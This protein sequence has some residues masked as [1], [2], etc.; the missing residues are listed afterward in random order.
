MNVAAPPQCR[1]AQRAVRVEG[2]VDEDGD[3]AGHGATPP[4]SRGEPVA[5]LS[6]SSAFGAAQGNAEHAH[7][8]RRCVVVAD[9]TYRPGE[10]AP[11]APT[12]SND[13]LDEDLR[14]TALVAAGDEGP[15][16]DVGLLSDLSDAVDVVAGRN[17][18][19]KSGQPGIRRNSHLKGIHGRRC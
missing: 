16:L 18:Q 7:Q 13:L 2:G 4:R 1:Q 11:L 9:F 14:V 19:D 8:G 5:D 10:L 3:S 12:V 17:R 15:L 6:G